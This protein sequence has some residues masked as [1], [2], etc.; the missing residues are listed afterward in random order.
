[1]FLNNALFLFIMIILL[2]G[3]VGTGKTTISN[4]LK[5][6]LPNFTVVH[7][8]EKIKPFIISYDREVETYDFDLDKFLTF[9]EDLLKTAR[10]NNENLI[11]EGH[12]AHFIDPNLVDYLFIISRNL[13]DLKEEYIKRGYNSRKIREN[14]EVESF[15]TCFIEAL[16]N[17]YKEGK[18]LFLI[19]NKDD[20]NKLAKNILEFVN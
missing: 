11:L 15:N 1:M 4:I 13:T 6:F 10:N 19:E 2:S 16:E 8:N 3:S 5:G 9:I 12:F 17:G 7:L 20:L 18:N 14:L